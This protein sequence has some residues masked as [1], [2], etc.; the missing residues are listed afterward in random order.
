MTVHGAQALM[1]R[2]DIGLSNT[3]Q[4]SASSQRPNQSSESPYDIPGK[5]TYCYPVALS[6]VSSDRCRRRCMSVLVSNSS[7]RSRSR[8]HGGLWNVDKTCNA[9]TVNRKVTSEWKTS[10]QV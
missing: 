10:I 5:Q 6:D 3:L 7:R 1:S 9:L 8:S 2:P 4:L